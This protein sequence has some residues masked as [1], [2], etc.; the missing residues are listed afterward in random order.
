M[1][2]RNAILKII[3]LITILFCLLISSISCASSENE[4]YVTWKDTD[5]TL[6][7]HSIVYSDYDPSLRK[8]PDDNDQWQYTGWN[9]I[10]SGNRIDCTA[11]RL[12]KSKIQW[13]DADGKIL[14]EENI[15][16]TDA[17]E[18]SYSLPQDSEVWHYTEWVKSITPDGYVYNAK[19]VPKEKHIWKDADGT[20]LKEE[21]VIE[22]QEIPTL[23]LP[24]EDEKWKYLKWNSVIE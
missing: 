17:T 13:V 11:L 6:L 22:G 10:K 1:N 2:K 15:V 7:E 21:Y 8:L 4:Y 18:F 3:G 5:G 24:A 14:K 20:V 23:D 12:K 16:V 19:R 9:V